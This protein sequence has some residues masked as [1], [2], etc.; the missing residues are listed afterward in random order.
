MV[1]LLAIMTLVA[2]SQAGI[3]VSQTSTIWA[4]PD[5]AMVGDTVEVYVIV[6]DLYGETLP[7]LSCTFYTEHPGIDFPVGGPDITDIDGFAQGAIRTDSNSIFFH[8]SHIYVDCEG[9]I[10]GPSTPMYWVCR[11][12]VDA[13]H[14]E[15]SGFGLY[16]NTPNP[17]K[18]NTEIR[19]ALPARADVSLEICDVLGK[20]VRTLVDGAVGVGYHKAAWDGKDALGRSVTPGVYYVRMTTPAYRETRSLILLR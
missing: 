17:F 14:G 16:Q 10:L 7:E 2:V 9:F 20:M 12:G 5:T 8:D 4:E 11:A 18:G 13:N 15:L 1:P 6:R 19:Y 3:P